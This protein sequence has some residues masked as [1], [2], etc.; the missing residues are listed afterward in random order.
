MQPRVKSTGSLAELLQPWFLLPLAISLLCQLYWLQPVLDE[1]E[2]LSAAAARVGGAALTR[3]LH[4]DITH[5]PLHL[6]A[7]HGWIQVLGPSDSSLRAFSMVCS[8]VALALFH[9]LALKFVERSGAAF[10]TALF[11][12]SVL[13]VF[14][15]REVRPFALALLLGLATL[16]LLTTV[17]RD[18]SKSRALLFGALCAPLVY[19]SYVGVLLIVAE[20]LWV[21]WSLPQSRVKLI[22]GGVVGAASITPYSLAMMWP[23]RGSYV[24]HISQLM[25]SPYHQHWT[26]PGAF[27]A[28][29]IAGTFFARAAYVL[30]PICAIAIV[31]AWRRFSSEPQ[32]RLLAICTFFPVVAL[33][34]IAL[35]S[36]GHLWAS[37]HLLTSGALFILIVVIGLWEH[38]PPLRWLIAVALLAASVFTMIHS[39][40]RY[41]WGDCCVAQLR[42]FTPK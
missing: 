24:H 5:P 9:L 8:V 7:L 31:P 23:Y 4:Y 15:A 34:V 16:H 38:R 35:L 2:Q 37:R 39:V 42:I 17:D 19:T 20:L 32:L 25:P 30:L 22:G 40:R 36:P 10:A 18:I 11:G 29:M 3:W 1:D 6:L 26:D 27:Y 28:H 33:N 41:H 13:F 12:C 14:Y 21:W